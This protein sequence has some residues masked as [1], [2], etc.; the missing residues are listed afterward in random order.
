MSLHEKA[1][2]FN[3][4]K[5]ARDEA[6][7]KRKAAVREAPQ[8]LL[9]QLKAELAAERDNFAK[10]KNTW[11]TMAFWDSKANEIATEKRNA[12][13]GG[14]YLEQARKSADLAQKSAEADSKRAWDLESKRQSV[15]SQ[16]ATTLLESIGGAKPSREL[17]AE[18]AKAVT[19]D[20]PLAAGKFVK[21]LMTPGWW[22]RVQ[23]L[24]IA[25]LLSSTVTH[26]ANMVGNVTQ[27]PLEVATHGMVVGI[28]WARAKATGGERQAYMA[29]LGPM[30]EAYGPGFLSSMPDAIKILQTGIT[31]ADAVKLENIRPGFASGSGKVDAVL[32]G[33]LRALQA[34]DE[35]FRG[36]A[37]A[38]QANRVATRYAIREGF[39]GA[40]LKGRA[41]NIVKN[42][43]DYPDLYSEAHAAMLRMVF[44]E[45]R[46]WIPSPRSAAVRSVVSQPLPFV[47]TPA[48]ITAQG[49]GLS[50]FG[51]ASAIQAVRARGAMQTA[52][53]ATQAQLGRA[54]LLAEQ[55]VA[56]TAL[57][58]AILG[59]GVGL[60]AGTFTAGKSMLTGAYDPNEA[61][62]YPQGWREWSMVTQDPVT[63]NTE[64]VPLQNFGAAGAPLAMAAIL[65]D[66]GKRGHSLLDENEAQRAATSIGQYVLD[67]TFLQGLSDTV[68]VLHDPSQVRQQVPRGIGRELRAIQRAGSPGAAC[69]RRGVEKPARRADGSGRSDGVELSRGSAGTCPRRSRRSASRGRRASRVPRRS[70]CR[71]GRTS[72]ATSRR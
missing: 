1:D 49:M 35:L 50:P 53:T 46:D 40:Q 42:L 26:M 57:G 11:E 44:Q 69:V 18:Y 4:L 59:L 34:E 23:M 2:D 25:G 67:N 5:A 38:M 21:G 68:N 22:G 15:Q 20:D 65:T 48:N 63:G 33:P 32:E 72:C 27:V 36:G 41:A 61:S 66:A 31:P 56:R 29:E 6:A 19:S 10:R 43:E 37:F 17:L 58:T 24:R 47:K 71:S 62:T 3:A 60:G 70:R 13:R 51:T 28:D 64:Y 14:L 9:T 30:L 8:E 45:H 12:F 16:K 7:A 54:T 52:G 39:S 55:R